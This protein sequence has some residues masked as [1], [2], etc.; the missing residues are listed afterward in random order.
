M[1]IMDVIKNRDFAS[2]VTHF[3]LPV[4]SHF[5][6]VSCELQQ[7]LQLCILI[8]RETVV[9]NSVDHQVLETV[10]NNKQ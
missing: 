1:Y 2:L 5:F 8:R 9:C 10:D 7:Q 3:S 4:Y 6:V